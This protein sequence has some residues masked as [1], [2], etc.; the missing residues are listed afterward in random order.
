M[1]IDGLIYGDNQ[2]F[3][4]NHRSYK[5][6][7]EQAARFA[8]LDEITKVYEGAISSGIRAVMLNSNDRADDICDW[9]RNRSGQYG[10]LNWYPSIPYPHKYA[11]MVT[12]RGPAGALVHSLRAGNAA[13]SLWDLARHGAAMLSGDRDYR[14]M[15]ILVDLEMQPFRGLT[16][17]TIFLQN[18]VVDLLV[19]LGWWQMVD[20]YCDHIRARYGVMP[21]LIT[22]NMPMLLAGLRDH[23]I[24]G[25]VICTSFNKIG[26]LM[27]PDVESYTEALRDNDPSKYP[28]MAM[29]VLASGALVPDEAYAFIREHRVQSVVFGASSVRNIKATVAAFGRLEGRV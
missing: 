5:K 26:Y 1:E 23:G 12:Q 14:A 21:G 6:A 10:H 4:I 16:V 18:V 20:A 3:G 17:R 25:V 13:R 28:I 15:K 11:N 22:Q 27:S 24:E 9:F 29:S 19:G 7:Q 2:F 8:E